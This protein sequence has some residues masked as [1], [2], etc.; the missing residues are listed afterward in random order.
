M[1]AGSGAA[2]NSRKRRRFKCLHITLV[3]F[4][5]RYTKEPARSKRDT[6]RML[7][8]FQIA[9]LRILHG[10][11]LAWLASPLSLLFPHAQKLTR[12]PKL[13]R[14]KLLRSCTCSSARART[15]G[16][17]SAVAPILSWLFG[18]YASPFTEAGPNSDSLNLGAQSNI[19]FGNVLQDTFASVK[20]PGRRI[21]GRL[22]STFSSVL[23]LLH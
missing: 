3:P 5:V 18:T 20:E 1:R 6:N 10:N 11:L 19:T 2:S 15:R 8:L 9:Y 23:L 4:W 17:L 12:Y 7:P 21:A 13:L 22:N 14:L 16:T